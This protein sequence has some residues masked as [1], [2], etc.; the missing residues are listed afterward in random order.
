MLA[1]MENDLLPTHSLIR[2]Q[3]PILNVVQWCV[4]VGVCVCIYKLSLTN[5]ITLDVVPNEWIVQTVL[6]TKSGC[7]T[8]TCSKVDKWPKLLIV[9]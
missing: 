8:V 1:Y 9:D 2:Q 7:R 6:F 4:G 5:K 3:T